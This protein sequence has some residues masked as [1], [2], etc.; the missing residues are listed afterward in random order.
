MLQKNI[1]RKPFPTYNPRVVETEFMEL[2]KAKKI[3]NNNEI[4]FFLILS[5]LLHLLVIFGIRGTLQGTIKN[6]SFGEMK[7]AFAFQSD[8]AAPANPSSPPPPIAS[9]PEL[10]QPDLTRAVQALE[11]EPIQQD[12]T[13]T[14]LPD[15]AES[16]PETVSTS[17]ATSLSEGIPG[18][19]EPLGIDQD[20]LQAY[21][22]EI[23]RLIHQAKRSYPDIAR[24]LGNQGTAILRLT[25][26]RNGTIQKIQ[27][28]Q[29]SGYQVLDE[30]ADKI[31][32]RAAPFPPFP[33]SL[34][35]NSLTID[36]P[37]QFNLLE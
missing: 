8:P 10:K 32:R 17:R 16:E 1:F 7:I 3:S 9:P 25:I 23:N 22:E 33:Q 27:I 6:P 11:N 21:L 28:G 36:I 20:E 15:I 18:N 26:N 37:F 34:N 29:H 5:V 13:L 35:I 30:S 4:G 31:I 19:P 14:A 12:E 24:R 2:G